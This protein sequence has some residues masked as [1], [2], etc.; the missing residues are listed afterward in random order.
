MRIIL[1]FTFIFFLSCGPEEGC[2][3]YKY[4]IQNKSGV[5][6]KIITYGIEGIIELVN[7]QE[8]SKT[9]ESC[10]HNNIPYYSYNNFFASDSIKIIF[11]SNKN[12]FFKR[13]TICEDGDIKKNERNLLNECFYNSNNNSREIFI[14]TSKDYE[15]AEDCNGD[16]E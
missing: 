7:N 16:C 8:K 13:E 5:S 2:E 15:K 12:L 6:I 4:T 1:F 3:S 14:F 10:S 9:Y 11:N